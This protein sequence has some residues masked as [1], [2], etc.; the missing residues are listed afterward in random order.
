MQI[1]KSVL[2]VILLSFCAFQSNATVL[3]ALSSSIEIGGVIEWVE[4]SRTISIQ[5]NTAELLHVNLTNA[6]GEVVYENTLTGNG[7]IHT[8]D[9]NHLPSGVY[10]FTA[11]CLSEI[12]YSTVIIE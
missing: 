6:K 1:L 11:S 12:V 3:P 2:V 5:A 8:I 7:Q 9:L 4:Q 10:K